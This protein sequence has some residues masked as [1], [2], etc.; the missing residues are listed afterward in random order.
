MIFFSRKNRA[1]E[2]GPYPLERLKRNKDFIELEANK[3]QVTKP[4]RTA[5]G[6]ENSFSQSIEKYLQMF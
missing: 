5:N 1:F 6:L 2:L 4:V 3:P